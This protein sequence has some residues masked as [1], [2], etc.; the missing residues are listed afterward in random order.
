MSMPSGIWHYYV[1][2]FWLLRKG[3]FAFICRWQK[4]SLVDSNWTSIRFS[5][6]QFGPSVLPHFLINMIVPP[7]MMTFEWIWGIFNHTFS[8]CVI[9]FVFKGE[10]MENS[11]W[12]FSIIIYIILSL[13]MSLYMY[14]LYWTFCDVKGKRKGERKSLNTM[15]WLFPHPIVRVS[16]TDPD[17]RAHSSFLTHSHLRNH[18]LHY[19]MISLSIVRV[20]KFS[21]FPLLVFLFYHVSDTRLVCT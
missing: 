6:L 7:L 19:P 17:L 11:L 9:L 16:I 3:A 14:V 5:D 21:R 18:L 20:S 13:F 1:Q 8:P 10:G 4:R 15:K 12:R 2:T